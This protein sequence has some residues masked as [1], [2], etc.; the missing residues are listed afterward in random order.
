MP[1]RRGPSSAAWVRKALAIQHPLTRQKRCEPADPA[2]RVAYLAHSWRYGARCVGQRR[3]LL[4]HEAEE[5]TRLR[6]R[7][8]SA[9]RRHPF[10]TG[11]EY[12]REQDLKRK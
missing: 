6:R 11:P 10:Y 4:L 9:G 12:R 2:P 7:G 1:T 8:S 3:R 5:D